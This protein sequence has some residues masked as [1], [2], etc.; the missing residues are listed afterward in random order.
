MVFTTLEFEATSSSSG[1]I[2]AIEISR[3]GDNLTCTCT[4]PA[5]QMGTYCKHR[6]G[7][8]NGDA[9]IATG[10]DIDK[11]HLVGDMLAGT[12]V[13]AALERLD[14]LE[15]QKADIDKQVKAAKKA[16]ARTLNN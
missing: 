14:T 16:L 11:M 2:Y 4:C 7:I 5:G 12:D 9:S 6:L 1:E 13:Q 3:H 8:L 10:G 15:K